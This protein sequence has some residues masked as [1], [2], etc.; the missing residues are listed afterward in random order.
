MLLRKFT[1]VIPDPKRSRCADHCQEVH[2]PD[3]HHEAGVEAGALQG[4]VQLLTAYTPGRVSE[5][6]SC[7]VL[8]A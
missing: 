5:L 7:T 1:P 4:N 8:S 2:L 6:I 3:L